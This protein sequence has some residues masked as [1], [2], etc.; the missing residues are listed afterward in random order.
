[1]FNMQNVVSVADLIAVNNVIAIGDKTECLGIKED[2]DKL[3]H[4]TRPGSRVHRAMSAVSEA[5]TRRLSSI[6]R[7]PVGLQLAS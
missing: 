1:M 7:N 3:F 4:Q 5:C 2:A 6:A